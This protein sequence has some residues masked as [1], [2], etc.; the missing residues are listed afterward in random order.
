MRGNVKVKLL[1]N[2]NQERTIRIT[3]GDI[4]VKHNDWQRFTE[5]LTAEQAKHFLSMLL[6]SG[7]EDILYNNP[8]L[9]ASYLD[10]T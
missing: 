1:S 7:I 4:E 2:L 10:S 8:R 6:Q 3:I 5:I 9:L